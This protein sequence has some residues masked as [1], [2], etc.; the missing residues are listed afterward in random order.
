MDNSW[1]ACRKDVAVAQKRRHEPL[2]ELNA[3]DSL[4]E[5]RALYTPCW[6][7]RYCLREFISA[8][9]ASMDWLPSWPE[10]VGF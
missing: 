3:T 1:K 4:V 9:R 7:F 5:R 10:P 2:T 8:M 6:L